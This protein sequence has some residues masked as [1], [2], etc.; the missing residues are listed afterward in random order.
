MKIMYCEYG[1]RDYK[2]ISMSELKYYLSE[3]YE[4]EVE[5]SIFIIALVKIEDDTLYFRECDAYD[6]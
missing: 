4:E 3:E 2:E 6:Y 1:K 5:L